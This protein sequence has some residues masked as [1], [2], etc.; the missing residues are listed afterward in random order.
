[1]RDLRSMGVAAALAAAVVLVP[2]TAHAD[3]SPTI[4][5]TATLGQAKLAGPD[6]VRARFRL[7]CPRGDTFSAFMVGLQAVPASWPVPVTSDVAASGDAT[8]TCRGTPQQVTIS[9]VN[10]GTDYFGEPV[11]VALHKGC[12][13]EYG[14]TFTGP[15]WFVAFDRGGADGG[16]DGPGPALCYR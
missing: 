9:L 10:H 12:S 2:G 8:G 16:P 7:T 5:D 1:M 3:E 11:Y 13:I 15:D 14:V 6:E 4:N